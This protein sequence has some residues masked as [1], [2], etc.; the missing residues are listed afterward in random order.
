MK[1][2]A[3]NLTA[4]LFQTMGGTYNGSFETNGSSNQTGIGNVEIALGT[5]SSF[6][7]TGTV[8]AWSNS[9]Q[10]FSNLTIASTLANTY[11]PS[12]ATGDTL[13]FA[14][15]DSS[16]N[17]VAFAASVTSGTRQQERTN[18]RG[19]QILHV[20][21]NNGLT[22][23]CSGTSGVDVQFNKVTFSS[24]PRHAR[25]FDGGKLRRGGGLEQE[26]RIREIRR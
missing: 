26:D 21:Y 19:N 16:G 9:G 3:G 12:F 14:G 6:D 1:S 20:T 4:T 18:T 22:G 10:Y 2:D 24:A 15:S 7:M 13:V 25:I 5:D 17:V 23:A 11:V 8:P